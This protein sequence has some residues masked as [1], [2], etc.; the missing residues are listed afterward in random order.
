MAFSG[1]QWTRDYAERYVHT[2]FHLGIKM[3]FIYILVGLGVELAQGWSQVV[4]HAP[5]DKVLD[6]DIAVCLATY[7]YYKLCLKIPDQAVSYLTGRLSMGFEAS[8]SVGAAFKAIPKVPSAV[9]NVVAGI[10]GFDK[11]VATAN[12]VA[13]SNIVAQG[14]SPDFKNVGLESIR[15]LG[16]ASHVEWE[17]KLDE[18]KGGKIAKDILASTLKPKKTSTRKPKPD[19]NP[20]PAPMGNA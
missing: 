15:T 9:T 14:K 18:T 6:V 12:Q 20:S 16:A 2:F 1:L 8:T 17:K 19:P 5:W 13:R 11:A 10:Q 7:I 3:V 4:I